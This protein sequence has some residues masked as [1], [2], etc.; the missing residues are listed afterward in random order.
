MPIRLVYIY[1]NLGENMGIF[2]E[3]D[4]KNTY[5]RW[6]GGGLVKHED[7]SEKCPGCAETTK[8]KSV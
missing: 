7:T 1:I 8:T 5:M 3:R 2:L 6:F 4:E